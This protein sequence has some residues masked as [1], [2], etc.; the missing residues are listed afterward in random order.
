MWTSALIVVAITTIVW[1][2]GN[3]ETSRGKR[4]T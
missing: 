4:E 2:T 3:Y 1:M